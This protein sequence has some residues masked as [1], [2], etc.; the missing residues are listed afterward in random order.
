MS[1]HYKKLFSLS[2]IYALGTMAEQAVFILLTP[3]LTKYLSP[4]DYGVLALMNLTIVL[5]TRGIFAPLNH[6]L[7]RYYYKPEYSSDKETLV[8]SLFTLLIV[9]TIVISVVYLIASEWLSHLLFSQADLVMLVRWYGVVLFLTPVSLLLFSF[10]RLLEKAKFYVYISICNIVITGVATVLILIKTDLGV[11]SVV[12]GRI[13]GLGTAVLFSFPVLLKNCHFKWSFQVIKEALRF[14]YPQVLSGYSNLL[15]QSGDRYVLRI[16]ESIGSIGLYSFGYKIASLINILFVVPM[17]E[18]VK[19]IILK[20]EDAP[21]EQRLFLAKSSTYFFL[22]SV[23]VAAG[24]SIFV[25]D[26][27]MLVARNRDFWPSW[28]LVPILSAAFVFYGLGGFARWGM[29]IKNKP[30]HMSVIMFVCA[31]LN[32]TLNFVFIPLY[33][34]AGAACTTL[35]TAIIW[36]VIRMYYSYRFFSQYFE[37]KRLVHIVVSICLLIAVAVIIENFLDKMMLKAFLKLVILPLYPAM[38]LLTGFF[39]SAEKDYILKILRI[40]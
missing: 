13:L 40:K 27:V 28:K 12:Y 37:W 34:I 24:V 20:K 29:V 8:F 19:P 5:I 3:I 36:C 9:K 21:D 7:M 17:R 10:I 4:G 1:K 32:I 38:L 30:Y 33:G 25:K 11:L 22:M 31:V 35:F 15:M 16:F 14:G 23:F 6:G 26:I 18:A 2:G 39:S